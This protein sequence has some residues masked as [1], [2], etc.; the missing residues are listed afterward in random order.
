M[1]KTK[2]NTPLYML[3]AANCIYAVS[4]EKFNWLFYVA[5]VL[6]AVTLALN[7]WEVIRDA[8]KGKE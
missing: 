8:R 7:I 6:T 1:R 2:I 5:L 4:E 3:F